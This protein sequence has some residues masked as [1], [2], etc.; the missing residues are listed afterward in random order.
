MNTYR[1]GQ[2]RA[3]ASR[4][5]KAFAVV[6]REARLAR[7]ISQVA[8]SEGANVDRTFVSMMEQGVNQ[9]S[10]TTLFKLARALGTRPSTLVA[11]VERLLR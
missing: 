11:R 6:L 8:L 7:G 5:S 9:A 4:V 3:E 10:L 1:A 2:R